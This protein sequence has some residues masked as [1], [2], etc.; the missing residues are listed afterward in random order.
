MASYAD[1]ILIYKEER[2][3][4]MLIGCEIDVNGVTEKMEVIVLGEEEA[5]VRD[6]DQSALFGDFDKNAQSVLLTDDR[7]ADQYDRSEEKFEEVLKRREAIDLNTNKKLSKKLV[8]CCFSTCGKF[9]C[10]GTRIAGEC[11][12]DEDSEI[13][14]VSKEVVNRD[15]SVPYI[16]ENR[17]MVTE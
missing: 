17:K 12:S 8:K 4:D 14:G 11:S 9:N 7:S 2:A 15:G 6:K 1:D 3:F 5:M 16:Q 13:N 10:R